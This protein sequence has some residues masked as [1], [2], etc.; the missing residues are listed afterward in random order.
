M[1]AR[2]P[3][4]FR[5]V[6]LATGRD[7]RRPRRAGRA[8]AAGR[9]ERRRRSRRRGLSTCRRARPGSADRTR[10]RSS[11]R[12]TTSTSSSSA[13]AASSASARCSPRW[14]RAR[15]SPPPTRRRSSRAAISSC[16]WPGRA[17]RSAPRSTRAIRSRARWPGSGRSTRSTRR[18]G[19][20]WPASRPRRIA[21]LLLTASGGPFLDAAAPTW[22]RSTPE[23]ALRHPTWQMGAKITIDS[24][25]LANK[26]LEVVEAHWLYDVELR[27]DRRGDPS[28]ERRPLRRRVRGRL[29]QGP[30]GHPGH[31]SPD[32]V[33][34]H[35][36]APR[37]VAGGRPGPRGPRRAHVPCPGRGALPGPPD[38]PRGGPHRAAGD[39]RPHRRRRGGRRPVPRRLARLPGH[40][41]P[42]RGRRGPVRRPAPTRSPRSTSSSPSTGRSGLAFDG[43]GLARGGRADGGPHGGSS[44]RRSRSS[45]SSRCSASSWSSTSSATSSSPG[46]PVSASSSS[47]S[48]SRPGPGSSA[49]RAR[50]SITLNWLPLGGF[51]RLEGEDGES[52]DPRSFVAGPAADQAH[53]PGRRR[54][55]ERAPGGRDLH[56]HRLGARPDRRDR[57]RDGPART[58]RPPSIGL[59]GYR[60]RHGRPRRRT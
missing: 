20:A 48:A 5:V 7:G 4:A 10:S 16:R 15:S 18:S 53:H 25:T 29:A 51:V 26:G 23:Q 6:A 50:R 39:R 34:P 52:D 33:R 24:A 8:P 54:G 43:A 9:R 57:V 36:P 35:L 28:P 41:A 3:D 12:A 30:A 21:R 11:R 49:R 2:H 55:D 38:R 58:R 47:G 59:V 22:R 1:L 27:R 14:P 31:A 56:G 40:P 46:W 19:S 42:A 17:P 60:R 37:R 44:A 45:S 32:P 13:R